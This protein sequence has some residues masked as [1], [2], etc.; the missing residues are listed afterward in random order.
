MGFVPSVAVTVSWIHTCDSTAW[1]R[2][3]VSIAFYVILIIISY[4]LLDCTWMLRRQFFMY[5]FFTFEIWNRTIYLKLPLTPE[6]FSALART[7]SKNSVAL[8]DCSFCCH[9]TRSTLG[10]HWVTL[11]EMPPY[12]RPAQSR[13][14]S[15]WQRAGSSGCPTSS[16]SLQETGWPFPLGSELSKQSHIHSDP[17][18]L[19]VLPAGCVKV[20]TTIT[21]FLRCV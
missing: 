10:G 3:R 20:A 19:W 9:S 14:C 7:L 15:E 11:W 12:P 18:V 17:S 5:P 2:Q 6:D 4:N 13:Q 1:K 21:E 16:G 8:R